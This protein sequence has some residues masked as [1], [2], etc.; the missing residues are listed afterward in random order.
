MFK[1]LRSPG[2]PKGRLRISSGASSLTEFRRRDGLI[3]KLAR[4]GDW[5][6]LKMLERG[7]LSIADIVAADKSGRLHVVAENLRLVKPLAPPASDK[8]GLA[9]SEET[10]SELKRPPTEVETWLAVSARAKQSRRRYRTSWVRFLSRARATRQLRKSAPRV[11]D[12]ADIDYARLQKEWGASSADWNRARAAVSS[13]LTYYL[14]GD[15][16]HP[17]RREVMRQF[18]TD[19]ESRGRI[20][21]ITPEQFWALIHKADDRIAPSLVAMATLGTGPGEYADITREDLN[22]ESFTVHIPGT[23]NRNRDREV[24]VDPRLWGWIDVA[25]PAPLAYRWLNEWFKRA[26]KEA[27]LPGTLTMYDLRHLSAQFAGDEGVTDRDL[28]VH[29]GH[30]TPAMSHRYSRRQVVRTV[31][32]AVADRLLEGDNA[33]HGRKKAVNDE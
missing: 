8:E 29:M 1:Q 7:E 13:F 15:L 4:A 19:E 24:A 33:K 11:G 26:R 9:W 31:A 2:N 23:K 32:G 14:N 18:K 30:S 12:L 5:D 3:T 17:F 28:T 25:I 6:T 10:L 16:Y 27:K 21:D 20:P 22:A